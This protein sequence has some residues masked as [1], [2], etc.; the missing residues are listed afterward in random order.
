MYATKY[1]FAKQ[2]EKVHAY[3]AFKENSKRAHLGMHMESCF[4]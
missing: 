3:E 1:G 2:D 4:R